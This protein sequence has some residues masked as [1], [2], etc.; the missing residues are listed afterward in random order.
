[1]QENSEVGSIV[2]AINAL[3]EPRFIDYV[4]LSVAAASTVVAGVS[5]FIAV[6]AL[7]YAREQKNIAERAERASISIE[8]LEILQSLKQY[9]GEIS[10]DIDQ[11]FKRLQKLKVRSLSVLSNDGIAFI[12]NVLKMIHDMPPRKAAYEN[13][14]TEE[15]AKFYESLGIDPNAHDALGVE[16]FDYKRFFQRQVFSEYQKL[17][18]Q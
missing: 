9:S 5:L 2:E 15:Q 14:A 10:D 18:V 4:S 1:M 16:Y 11:T 12:N 3:A 7:R 13:E 8:L 6:K 17:F